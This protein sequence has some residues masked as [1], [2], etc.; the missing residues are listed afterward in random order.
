MSFAV[1]MQGLE[2]LRARFGRM[3]GQVRQRLRQVVRDMSELVAETARAN[4]ARLFKGPVAEITTQ[5]TESGDVITGTITAGGTPFAAIHEYGGT[6][7]IPEIFP[8]QARRCIGSARAAP[9][10]SPGMPRRT[11][12][13]SP[14]APIC[15]APSISVRPTSSRRFR[16]SAA[17]STSPR[18]PDGGGPYA[19]R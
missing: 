4:M 2:L 1:E 7:H 10:S 16:A 14:S 6:V 15:A 5:V 9:R 12:C 18:P 3:P 19:V 11:M 13:G 17:K 8:V